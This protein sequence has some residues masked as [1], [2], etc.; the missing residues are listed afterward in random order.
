ME[1]LRIYTSDGTQD[2]V[3]DALVQLSTDG[4]EWTDAFEIGDGVA[5]TAEQA[6]QTMGV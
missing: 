5:D 6:N 1:S 4:K 2:Y 3:R